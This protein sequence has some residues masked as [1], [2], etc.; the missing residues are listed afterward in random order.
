[1]LCTGSARLGGAGFVR[2]AGGAPAEVIAR[3]PEVVISH[4]G[5]AGSGRVQAWAIGP[6]GGVDDAARE[7]LNV[8]LAA[9]VPVLADADA[10]TLIANSGQLAER[11]RERYSAGLIT[12]ITPHAGEFARLG[13]HL[14]Q[15]EQSDRAAAV[16]DAARQLRAL[17]LL[18]GS[19]TIVAGPNGKI[20][21]NVL[22]SPSLATAGSGDVLSGL[23]GSMLASAAARF[24]ASRTAL[25][26]DAAVSVVASAALVHGLA[27]QISA[28]GGVPVT[29]QSVLASVPAAIAEARAS[30]GDN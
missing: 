21:V 29:A 9:E 25:T 2:Y 8:V 12:A 20:V 14:G 17:V 1:V 28:A 26:E 22:S 30:G 23:A 18:K 24:E 19:H 7:R 11:I 15:G 6:G 4:Q 3:W 16:A 5:P 27:G 10:L 13:F